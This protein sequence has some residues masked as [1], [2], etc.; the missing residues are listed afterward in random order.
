M[1]VYWR[2]GIFLEYK[3]Y[4]APKQAPTLLLSHEH[5]TMMD[6]T[7][8][9]KT[10]DRADLDMDQNILTKKKNNEILFNTRVCLDKGIRELS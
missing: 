4:C 5:I 3:E 10:V 6:D 7:L 9:E 8:H 1:Q 2:V